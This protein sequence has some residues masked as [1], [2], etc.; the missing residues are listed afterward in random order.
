MKLVEPD[1]RREDRQTMTIRAELHLHEPSQATLGAEERCNLDIP[2]LADSADSRPGRS[3]TETGRTY[4]GPNRRTPLTMPPWSHPVKHPAREALVDR[5][6]FDDLARLL[7]GTESRRRLI[8]WLAAAPLASGLLD[9]LDPEDAEAA[10]RRRR[11]KKRHKHGR[12]RR[13]THRKRKKK[14]QCTPL[15]TCPADKVCGTVDDGCGGTITCGSCAN[16]TPACVNNACAACTSSEQ[17][18]SGEL[19][20]GGICQACDVCA[21]GCAYTTV[22][23][24]ITAAAAG[25]TIF[26]CAGTYGRVGTGSAAFINKNL[27]VVGA[28][29]GQSGTILDGGGAVSGFPV[30]SLYS[31][32]FPGSEIELR[33]LTVTGGNA[34]A[35]TGGIE[36]SNSTQLTLTRVHVTEN[37]AAIRAGGIGNFGTLV[38][39]AGTEVTNNTAGDDAGGILNLFSLAVKDGASITNNTATNGVGGGILNKGTVTLEAGADLSGNEPDQCVEDGGTGC[40]V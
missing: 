4:R 27:T 10:G 11:R 24:A 39:N 17:C 23:A 34:I 18:P 7:A 21:A 16:P 35:Q 30:V 13:R 32:D 37:R 5:T 31:P 2:E 29:T 22:Q 9:I 19:C 6:R 8:G 3:P 38:L 40:P 20:L 36:V 26:V 25:D 12:G 15:T 1:A 28:G 33:D 14:P